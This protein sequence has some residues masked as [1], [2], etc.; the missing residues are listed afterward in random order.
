MSES[1]QRVEKHIIKPS[2]QYFS[3]IMDFCR[4]S[5]NLYNHANFLIRKEFTT[6]E[7]WIRYNDLDKILK[8]DVEYP[9]YKDMPSA[10]SAQQTL[11]LIDKNWKS[12]FKSIKDWSK[13]KDKYLGKPIMPKYLS[14]NGYYTLIL[15]NQVYKLKSNVIYFPKTF[16]GFVL[17]PQFVNRS[18]F[19]SFQQVRFICISFFM[20]NCN[21]KLQ[22]FTK[23]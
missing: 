20:K 1:C 11:R 16:N 21:S 9:D 10:Q 15:T 2:D 6:S 4:K 22:K 17:F 5:K 23:D 19:K 14:K 3:L 12:F 18:D 13:N 8:I 7:K